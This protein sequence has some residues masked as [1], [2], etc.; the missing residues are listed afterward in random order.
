MW[1]KKFLPQVHCFIPIGHL[2]SGNL[3]DQSLLLLFPLPEV[4]IP[5]KLQST[6]DQNF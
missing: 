1:I 5:E 3:K 2:P 6:V 4:V